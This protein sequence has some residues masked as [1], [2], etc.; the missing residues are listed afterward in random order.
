[1]FAYQFTTPTFPDYPKYGVWP[2]AYYASTNESS[3]AVY[4]YNRAQMLVGGVATAQRFTAPDLAGFGFQALIPAD[5]D[6]ANPPPAGAP[7]PFMRH[8]DDEAHNP[9]SNDPAHD[10]VE[11]WSYHVDFATPAN[12]TFTG[13]TNIQVTEFDSELCGFTSF[14]CF[15][16]P[17]S[18]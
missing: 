17:S 5:A 4:A 1:W 14:N 12:S 6:G 9:G 13:P 7:N 18:S 16:Q 15:P 2:D 3:P 11:V 10:F 8:R